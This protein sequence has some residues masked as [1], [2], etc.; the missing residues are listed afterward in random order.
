MTVSTPSMYLLPSCRVKIIRFLS[1]TFELLGRKF[2]F[3]VLKA[4]LTSLFLENK[5]VITLLSS[6]ACFCVLNILSSFLMNNRI[7]WNVKLFYVDFKEYYILK[8]KLNSLPSESVVYPLCP[9]WETVNLKLQKK[10]K[11]MYGGPYQI[12]PKCHSPVLRLHQS[13]ASCL[14]FCD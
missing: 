10:K 7:V 5:I 3:V 12:Q 14:K 8:N 9:A 2:Q 4:L 13:E 11:Y 6:P 1:E